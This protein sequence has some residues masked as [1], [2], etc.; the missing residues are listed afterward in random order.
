M[1]LRALRARTG[2]PRNGAGV[3]YTRGYCVQL[4]SNANCQNKGPSNP[5]TGDYQR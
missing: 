1:E 3:I 2:T 4:Y 5:Y